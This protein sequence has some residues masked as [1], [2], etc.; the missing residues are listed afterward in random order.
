M[1]L[2]I[3]MFMQKE[4]E[5]RGKMG[6]SIK[7]FPRINNEACLYCFDDCI[8]TIAEEMQFDY[9]LMYLTFFDIEFL[10][11][12]N[13]SQKLGGNLKLNFP[14]RYEN[15][16]KNHGVHIVDV[17]VR[18]NKENAI[19]LLESEIEQGNKCIV[20]FDPYWC[21][22]DLQ[23]K[24]NHET[25][26]GHSLVVIDVEDD[27]I[28]MAD[29]YFE[30]S[31]K[32]MS[33]NHFEQGVLNILAL[34]KDE[35]FY[36]TDGDLYK[37][38]KSSLFEIKS[39][40]TLKDFMQIYNNFCLCEDIHSEVQDNVSYFMSPVC[41]NFLL[42]NQA[43]CYYSVALRKIANYFSSGDNQ[44][45]DFAQQLWSIGKD[46]SYFRMMM[47]IDYFSTKI[48]DKKVLDNKLKSI[49]YKQQEVFY[50]LFEKYCN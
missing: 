29:P 49:V 4:I 39:K 11:G 19:M 46:W 8:A 48:I 10:Y 44:L 30:Y 36:L 24:R 18:N 22:W 37:K 12:R 50:E 33:F 7:K 41:V 9:E 42:I 2:G 3:L 26:S 5:V 38:L 23:Y 16:A 1:F 15:L 34:H 43:I 20:Y 32:I 40:N 14:Q 13:E 47:R 45:E 28:H 27:G 25:L 17:D 21:P 6:L 31:E 35:N